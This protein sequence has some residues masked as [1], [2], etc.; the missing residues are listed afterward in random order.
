M[1]TEPGGTLLGGTDAKILKLADDADEDGCYFFPGIFKR[2]GFQQ[3][4]KVEGQVEETVAERIPLFF[5][6]G[7]LY[8]FYIVAMLSVD[9]LLSFLHQPPDILNIQFSA[10]DV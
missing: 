3:G 7:L 4:R 1:G 5:P 9:L 6:D 2:Q 8:M 10:E